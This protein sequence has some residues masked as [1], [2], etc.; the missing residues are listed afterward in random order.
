M[1]NK[2][3]Q[4]DFPCPIKGY[5]LS[6]NWFFC[7][8]IIINNTYLSKIVNLQNNVKLH[9]TVY[10]LWPQSMTFILSMTS[11][12]Q[13]DRLIHLVQSNSKEQKNRLKIWGW[14]HLAS[15]E[16]FFTQPA[17]QK[18]C[19]CEIVWTGFQQQIE[20]D[21]I[22]TCRNLSTSWMLWDSFSLKNHRS[23]WEAAA[24]ATALTILDP[25][26]KAK[27]RR[28]GTGDC[29]LAY[30]VKVFSMRSCSKLVEVP[31]QNFVIWKTFQHST[32]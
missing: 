9:N 31:R 18:W 7:S 20:G 24:R 12:I 10:D 8:V 1:K 11:H 22:H 30:R 29:L 28:S 23:L 17:I 25:A 4:N 26:P 32:P 27:W 19:K 6:I 15:S 5:F 2:L 21:V 14:T 3:Q 13:Y 16:I